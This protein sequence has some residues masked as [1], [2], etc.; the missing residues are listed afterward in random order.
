MP[1]KS[2]AE[3]QTVNCLG[4]QVEKTFNKKEYFRRNDAERVKKAA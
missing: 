4:C 3:P 2:K 1:S